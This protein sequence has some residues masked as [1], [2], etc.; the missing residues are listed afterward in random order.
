[1]NPKAGATL[2]LPVLAE[3]PNG[4]DPHGIYD[5]FL[6]TKQGPDALA[7]ALAE[8]T[9]PQ[10]IALVGMNKAQS[11]AT[12]PEALVAALRKAGDIQPMKTA[13]SPEEMEAV[14]KRVAENGDAKRGEAI[15]RRAALQCAVCHAI[16]GAG[17]VIGPDLVS[18]GASAPVDY[19]VDSLLEPS[20]KIKEG[21]HTT[22]VT[23]KNGNAFAG[24]I[25][26]EDANEIVVRDAAGQENRLP[27]TE[28][29][30]QQ[31]SPVSLM[32]PGLTA[33]LRE[34]EFIH[35][36]RFLA[37]LGKDGPYKTPTNRFMRQWQALMPHPSTRDRIG[38]YGSKIFTEDVPD[39]QWTPLYATVAGALPIAELPEVEGRG[40]NRLGV[41]RT[42]LDV[43]S[44]GPMKVKLTGKLS[45]LQLFLDDEE[46]TLPGEGSETELVLEWNE[47]GKRKLTLVGVKDQGLD[48]I[49]LE[50]LEDA[51][52]AGLV[53]LRD[54]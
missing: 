46:I 19:L 51:T 2:A 52:K 39:Y 41:L 11:A 44:A 1:M 48:S 50:L 32:P 28:I 47:P 30:G 36:V 3:A 29:A 10:P 6:A 17:G 31:I 13:L 40:K 33:S 37:E 23:L 15:Y 25:A 12:R 43:K 42:F 24:A 49:S 5:A 38:H 35:L 9:L 34:D 22:L 4:T 20:K 27:K 45:G 16:G 26:R 21:Y 18:I 8:A 7:A 53:E 54:F 14:M